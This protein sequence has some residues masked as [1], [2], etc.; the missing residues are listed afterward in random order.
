MS[1]R[2]RLHRSCVLRQVLRS[3]ADS[4]LEAVPGPVCAGCIVGVGQVLA[5]VQSLRRELRPLHATRASRWSRAR[6]RR[7]S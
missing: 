5:E 6:L 4:K 2:R 1:E 3:D 7:S